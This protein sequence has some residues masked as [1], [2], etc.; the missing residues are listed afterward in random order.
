MGRVSVQVPSRKNP[1]DYKSK[2]RFE[3]VAQLEIGCSFG[4]LA[5]IIGLRYSNI[6]IY[7]YRSAKIVSL[8]E[9]YF[10]VVPN[11]SFR[12]ILKQKNEKRLNKTIIFLLNTP[13]FKNCRLKNLY[14]V[15]Y[16]FQERECIKGQML[17][18]LGDPA[19]NVYLVIDGEFEVTICLYIN[20]I[21]ILAKNDN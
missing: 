7:I 19:S 8:E 6:Y 17:C 2:V 12:S 10:A 9:A 1:A 20:T 11:Y 16:Y 14:L 18:S 21:Y 15:Q 4:E 5:C 13:Y 3:E